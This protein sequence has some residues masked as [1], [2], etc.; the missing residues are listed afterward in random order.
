MR[1]YLTGYMGAGKTTAAKRLANK[2]GW[3]FIDLDKYIEVKHQAKI[4]DIFKEQGE[5]SF[6]DFEKRALGDTLL[7]QRTIIATGGGTPCFNNLMQTMTENGLCIYLKMP[8]K[9][10]VS[11]LMKNRKSRPILKDIPINEFADFIER[12]LQERERFYKQSHFTFEA[13]D[14]EIV[15]KLLD[16][17]LEVS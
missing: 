4:T 14:R 12:S 9:A 7:W 2:L 3:T 17:V 8:A 11:R 10:L 6:R 5:A 1:V 15:N 13:L 16:C